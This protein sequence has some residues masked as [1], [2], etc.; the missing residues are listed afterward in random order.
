MAL[1]VRLPDGQTLRFSAAFHIGREHGCDVELADSHVSRRHAEV[2]PAGAGWVIRDLQSSNGLLVDGK[3][4]DAAPVG[5]GVTITFG[6]GGPTLRI[7]PESSAK[8]ARPADDTEEH[9]LDDYAQRYFGSEDDEE[10][11]GD[12][13]L[14]IRKAFQKVQQHQR[15]RQR[16][17]I[18]AVVLVALGA[19]GYALY[20]HRVIRR[21]T[22]Q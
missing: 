14:M 9:T 22:Q 19:G 3:R 13:T 20:A 10:P 6:D 11:V 17:T 1:I 21:Q 18:A 7:E 2:S 5:E 15:R 16:L 12:R 8:A 4:V